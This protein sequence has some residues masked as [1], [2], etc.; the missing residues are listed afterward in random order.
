MTGK[1]IF[2]PIPKLPANW[3]TGTPAN[4]PDTVWTVWDKQTYYLWGANEGNYQH[5]AV[6]QVIGGGGMAGTNGPTE[7]MGHPHYIGVNT[8]EFA[9]MAHNDAVFDT[10][11]THI[12]NGQ[13][14][15][16]PIHAED[17]TTP[18]MA[19]YSLGTGLGA[20]V[21]NWADIQKYI[22]QKLVELGQAAGTGNV[23]IPHGTYWPDCRQT[24]FYPRYPRYVI[25]SLDDIQTI[26]SVL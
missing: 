19:Q 20:G 22:F 13:N 7:G 18:C 1:L 6:G 4:D 5:T 21:S 3:W 24:K 25:T 15:V 23:E 14:V 12:L 16:V 8:M 17:K 9:D 11:K 10:L 2:A 26:I